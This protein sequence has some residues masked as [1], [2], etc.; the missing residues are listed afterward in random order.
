MELFRFENVS[1]TTLD[2]KFSLKNINW[3]INNFENWIIL[4][5]NGSEKTTLL[6]MIYDFIRPNKTSCLY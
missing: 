2:K 4:G 6:K 3:T 5:A 1:Y